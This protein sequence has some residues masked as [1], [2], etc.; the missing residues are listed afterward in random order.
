TCLDLRPTNAAGRANLLDQLRGLGHGHGEARRCLRPKRRRPQAGD[1]HDQENQ[2]EM[3]ESDIYLKLT[4]V[5]SGFA[6]IAVLR[7]PRTV[8]WYSTFRPRVTLSPDT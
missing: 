1:R 7:E 2:R 5:P 8:T 4:T 3:H 6:I